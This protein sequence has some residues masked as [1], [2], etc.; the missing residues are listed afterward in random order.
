MNIPIVYNILSRYPTWPTASDLRREAAGR[1]PHSLRLQHPEGVDPSPRSSAEGWRQETQEEELHHPQEDQAQE[2]EGEAGCAQILQ[3]RR[4]REDPATETRVPRARLRC[5][6]IHG[7][8]L[9]STVLWKVWT[10]LCL[11]K[12]RWWSVDDGSSGLV[13]CFGFFSVDRSSS[14]Y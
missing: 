9:W 11:Q 8:S 7:S 14:H 5:R 1:W 4:Q 13:Y 12:I 2:K 6:D 3:G 10:D